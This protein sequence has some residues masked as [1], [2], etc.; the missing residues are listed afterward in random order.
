MTRVLAVTLGAL[1]QVAAVS[2][3]S[4]CPTMPSESETLRNV[5][6]AGNNVI[7]GS[8]STLYRLTT[9]L[10][11]IESVYLPGGRR[12]TNRLLVA[13]RIFGGAVLACGEIRCNLSPINRL[14]DMVW[15]GLVLERD[16]GNSNVLAA[17]SLTNNGTL[18]VTYGTRQSA[19]SSSTITRGSLLDS[20]RQGP[21]T[22]SV[23][24]EQREQNISVM[25]EFLAVFSNEGYQFFVV[26]INNETHITRLCLSDNGEE[27][28]PLGTFA[29][30]IELELKCLSSEFATAANFVNSTEPFGVETVLVTFQVT[31]SDMFHICAFNLSE[32][33][34][35][36]DRKFE[37][38]ITA[39]GNAG[40][41][42]NM[43]VPCQDILPNQTEGMVCLFLHM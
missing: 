29:S 19:T 38:C 41:R 37:A 35:Q 26:R 36:M 25:R 5:V 10:V 17:L 33:N 1:F 39:S 31:N 21:Y 8:S 16:P 9:D 34:K 11:E 18:S 13:D 22:Y 15:R 2:C 28:S 43:A 14:S 23:Y 24:A 7:V 27:P 42:R 32:I 12:S 30:Y 20:F 6:V 40:L 4:F 3:L